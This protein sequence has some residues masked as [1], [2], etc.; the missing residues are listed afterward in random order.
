MTQNVSDPKGPNLAD[1][2]AFERLLR[3]SLKGS[4]HA[5]PAPVIRAPAEPM[6]PS[7]ALAELARIV[8]DPAPFGAPPKFSSL[9]K[10][11][12]LLPAS[13]DDSDGAGWLN[14][15]EARASIQDDLDALP[16]VTSRDP[17]HEFEEELRRFDQARSLQPPPP[18]AEPAPQWQYQIPKNVSLTVSDP[19]PEPVSAADR[20]DAAEARLAQEA[21][22]AAESERLPDR[23][24]RIFIALGGVA[25]AGIVAIIGIFLFSSG[26]KP[27][28]AA[29]V[30]VIAANPAPTK[31]KPA[32]PGGVEV[33]DQNK[34]ILA[35]KSA[36]E[37]RPGQIV[38]STE[39]PIDLN[40][41]TRQN[42]ARIV[43][44]GSAPASSEAGPPVSPVNPLEPRRVT[45][46]RIATPDELRTN[47]PVAAPSTP[48]VAAVPPSNATRPTG[49]V[50]PALT[51]STQPAPPQ[52]PV[53]PVAA[54]PEPPKTEP[55]KVQ[56]RP[57]MVASAPVSPP[58]PTPSPAPSRPAAP[59]S[60]SG[61]LNLTPP[62][63]RLPNANPPA[64]R[65][66]TVTPPATSAPQPSRPAASGGDGAWA[67]QLAS[68]PTEADAVSASTQLRSRF[69]SAIGDRSPMVVSGEANG[70]TVYRVRVAGFSQADAAEACEKVKA[71]GG[72]CFV[73]R[74]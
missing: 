40:Q 66:A 42:P 34:A 5:V 15:S 53:A 11:D 7:S 45:S 22:L 43:T 68:R 14:P 26:N 67:I 55:P 49:S 57:P 3:D 20:L 27:Q 61:P 51:P 33:P 19:D 1:L 65:T 29:K 2:E 70:R 21:A 74:Q 47:A 8:N 63:A 18:V 6:A 54:T 62:A 32:N 36:P 71:A 58:A 25:A 60:S 30:P 50:T 69:A 13:D 4:D 31:E 9:P 41:V 16:A 12:P 73:T 56:T 10:P 28:I 48:P 46:V 24:K 64:T 72:G 17:L 52:R 35:P 39:Q 37:T 59:G 23:S 44:P 38:N